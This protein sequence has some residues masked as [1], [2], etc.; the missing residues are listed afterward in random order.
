MEKYDIG[1]DPDAQGNGIAVYKN[2]KLIILKN[3]SAAAFA[4]FLFELTSNP[5]NQ[6]TLHIEDVLENSAVFKGRFK[7]GEKLESKLMKAQNL[8]MCKQAQ[9]EIEEAAKLM[10]IR[11]F[12]YQISKRWKTQNEKS[13]FERATGWTKNSNED[14]RSAA[15]F[16]FMGV[17]NGNLITKAEATSAAQNVKVYP[18]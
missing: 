9:R 14:T 16:G 13:I 3:M 6:V 15:F 4:L 7:P 11:I 17:R 8:G 18:R 10:K 1:C 12:R 5:E 2:G